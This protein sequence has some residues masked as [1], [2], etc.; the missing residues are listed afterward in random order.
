MPYVVVHLK[1]FAIA[2]LHR[3]N[4]MQV[5]TEYLILGGGAPFSLPEGTRG[6]G[7]LINLMVCCTCLYMFR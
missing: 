4:L 2:S 3:I 1:H 6:S 7:F 5:S